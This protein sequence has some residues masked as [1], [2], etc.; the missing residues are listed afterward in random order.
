LALRWTTIRIAVR[1][2]SG[3]LTGKL[4]IRW[5]CL[6]IAL[7]DSSA[8]TISPRLS[9]RKRDLTT[10]SSPG[11]L[12]ALLKFFCWLIALAKDVA[13]FIPPDWGRWDTGSPLAS[14]CV[15]AA[16]VEKRFVLTA[17]ADFSSTS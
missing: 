17:M 9:G 5:F 15:L 7:R 13:Y 8:F 6:R 12:E 1:G 4:V 11:T 10:A 2:S 16:V 14:A 3:A